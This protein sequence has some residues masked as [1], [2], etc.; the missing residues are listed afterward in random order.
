M[1][2]PRFFSSESFCNKQNLRLISAA[3]KGDDLSFKRAHRK[4][5]DL[6]QIDT[7]NK[8][9]TA[10]HYFCQIG[11]REGVSYLIDNCPQSFLN[12]Q[13]S[14]GRTALHYAAQEGFIPIVGSLLEAGANPKI[15]DNL[16][17]LPP[18]E[19]AFQFGQLRCFKVMEAFKFKEMTKE[20]LLQSQKQEKE[21]VEN[22]VRTLLRN[23][24]RNCMLKSDE[25]R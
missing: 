24:A 6:T 5:A 23:D 11:S 9:Y 1:M 25:E 19:H 20:E 22:A 14:D 10:L 18:K 21:K 2:K 16:N 13:D 8:N 7:S 15:K 3:K 17:K 4:G 12:S